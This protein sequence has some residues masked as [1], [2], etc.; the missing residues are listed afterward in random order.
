MSFQEIEGAFSTCNVSSSLVGLTYAAINPQCNGTP[1]SPDASPDNHADGILIGHPTGWQS[2]FHCG[3]KS[4]PHPASSQ[5]WLEH[6]SSSHNDAGISNRSGRW[7]LSNPGTI[8]IY[9]Q[10]SSDGRDRTV[11]EF[12]RTSAHEFGHAI[13]V[14]DGIGFGYNNNTTHGDIASLMSSMWYS[15]I[16]GAT[17]LDLELAWH[18]QTTGRRRAWTH[19][20]VQNIINTYGITRVR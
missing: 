4:I 19:R 15:G 10:F 6:P 20:S 12:E 18:A 13:G 14:L 5:Y 2:G 9:T 3:R 16:T 1:F 8:T 17:Q 11:A 7:T